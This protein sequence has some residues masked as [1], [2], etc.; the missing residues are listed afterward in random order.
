[1]YTIHKARIS[2]SQEDHKA[3]SILNYLHCSIIIKLVAKRFCF[4]NCKKKNYGK[5]NFNKE[6]ST[7][8]SYVKHQK[9]GELLGNT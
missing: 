7:I 2:K 5:L 9:R 4:N 6:N 3:T 8:Y 1:M